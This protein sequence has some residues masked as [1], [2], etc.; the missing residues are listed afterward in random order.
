VGGSLSRDFSRNAIV[1]ILTK[2]MPMNRR[3]AVDDEY[4]LS[5][6]VCAKNTSAVRDKRAVVS[7][8]DLP[9]ET[10]CV[11]IALLP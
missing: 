1:E 7:S 11:G 9:F 6:L 4:R 10:Q 8:K 2:F 5:P 3:L